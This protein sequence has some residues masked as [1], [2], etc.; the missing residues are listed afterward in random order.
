MSRDSTI[1][2]RYDALSCRRSTAT[3]DWDRV[4]W[5]TSANSTGCEPQKLR[6][7]GLE[8]ERHQITARGVRNAS[9]T[10]GV[11]TGCSGAVGDN[12]KERGSFDVRENGRCRRER[13]RLLGAAGEKGFGP[14]GIDN[15]DAEYQFR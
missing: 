15:R 9:V 10:A 14:V 12:N 5:Q 4:L 6:L 7:R 3:L 13:M 11:P 2:R 8:F 1:K